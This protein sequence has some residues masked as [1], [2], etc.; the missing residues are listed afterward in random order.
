MHQFLFFRNININVNIKFSR[1]GRFKAAAK[2][3]RIFEYLSIVIAK[4]IY[5]LFIVIKNI[6]YKINLNNETRNFSPNFA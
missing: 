1:E 5:S 6:V 4:I 3:I 2:V